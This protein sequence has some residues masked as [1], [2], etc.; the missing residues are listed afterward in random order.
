[1]LFF[2]NMLETHKHLTSLSKSLV[3][4]IATLLIIGEI[5]NSLLLQLFNKEVQA[6]FEVLAAQLFLCYSDTTCIHLPSRL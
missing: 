6:V 3:T 5:M 4:V 1:M 2:I